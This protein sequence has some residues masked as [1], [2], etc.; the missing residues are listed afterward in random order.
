MQPYASDSSRNERIQESLKV[1]PHSIEAE[2]SVLGGLMLDNTS[3][4]RV[5]D[6]VSEEDFYRSD[7]RLIFRALRSLAEGGSPFD[8]V[9]LGEWLAKR[10]QLDEIG[11]MAAL[12]VLARDTPSAANIAAYADIVRE[13]SILRQLIRVGNEIAESAYSTQGRG[14]KD[15]LDEAEK[16]VF[17]I[18]VRRGIYPY[19][20]VAHQGCRS[21]RHAFSTG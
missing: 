10:S 11:G 21:Y 13:R 20:D 2:Q 6:R 12:A 9:T 17:A 18:A 3:W 8:V 14:S 4:D 1:T 15:L 16:Q 19:Q 7:H 5:A